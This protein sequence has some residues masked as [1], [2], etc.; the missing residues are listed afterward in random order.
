M[1]NSHEIPYSIP[2]LPNQTRSDLIQAFDS[3]I[4]SGSGPAVSKVES[5]LAAKLGLR[6]SLTV[7]NGSAALRLAFQV[8]NLRPG[9]KVILPAWGFHVAANIAHSMGAELEFRDVGISSWCLEPDSHTD[10]LESEEKSVLVLIHTLGNF[11]KMKSAKNFKSSNN[12]FIIEDSAEALF[13]HADEKA[14][15]TIFDVGT[16]SFHAAKTITSGE[17]GLFVATKEKDFERARLIRNHGMAA[18]RPYFHHVAGDNFRLSN[19]LA[20]ILLEQ[21]R[22]SE[23]II[24]ERKNVYQTYLNEL[25]VFPSDNFIQPTDQKGFFPW[26][27]GFRIPPSSKLSVDEVRKEMKLRGIDTRPGF[28][29]ATELPYFD[30]KMIPKGM[31]LDNSR[32]LSGEVI[33][34][35][36]YPTMRPEDVA[37]V[38]SSLVE[39]IA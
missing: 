7:S 29:S 35:P 11:G 38:C 36:H 28:T 14:L 8:S 34:L 6:E 30:K 21:I 33:L 20:S 13:S 27:F 19:L 1:H 23:R 5:L 39:I 26:G 37:R 25:K 17:G 12:I 10:I 18:G 22:V 32:T 3:G 15:G 16:Y 2:Y 9:M 4:I 24:Q 31:D